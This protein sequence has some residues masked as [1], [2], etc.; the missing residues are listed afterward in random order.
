MWDAL[1]RAVCAP[2]GEPW[3][4]RS[5][6]PA[7][8]GE[9]PNA[10]HVSVGCDGQAILWCFAHQCGAEQIVAAVGLQMHDLFPAGHRRARRRPLPDACRADFTGSARAVANVLAGLEAV[11]GDWLVQLRCD[12]AHCGAPAAVLFAD[13]S[14]VTL[15]CPGDDRAQ[16]LGYGACTA[17]QLTQA[18]AG[19]L[20]DA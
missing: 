2:H 11:G 6:C 19:R 8:D 14:G 1:E 9:N 15:M 7:H 20:E 12:C 5:R 17:D 13:R 18:L 10:L 16:A 4:F 3:N